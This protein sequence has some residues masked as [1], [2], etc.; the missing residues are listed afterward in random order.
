MKR[1]MRSAERLERRRHIQILIR[2]PEE[3]K[4]ALK[5]KSMKMGITLNALILQIL[6]EWI[7]K[8]AG[9]EE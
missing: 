9:G 1:N 8:K 5:E 4:Q 2:A 6:W 3:L 7:E